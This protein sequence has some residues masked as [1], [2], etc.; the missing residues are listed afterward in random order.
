MNKLN[1]S[2][3]INRDDNSLNDYLYCYNLFGKVP[4]RINIIGHFKYLEFAK[5]LM[6]L[7]HESVY[8]STDIITNN[9]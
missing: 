3:N 4:S 6:D 1:N 7:E 9:D 5:A 8:N 2:V